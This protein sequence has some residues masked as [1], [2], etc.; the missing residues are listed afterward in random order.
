MTGG[1][2]GNKFGQAFDNAKDNSDEKRRMIQAVSGAAQMGPAIVAQPPLR[3]GGPH[4]LLDCYAG[5]QA[6]VQRVLSPFRIDEG[7]GRPEMGKAQ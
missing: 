5:D 3:P 7:F 4:E 1:R 6:L 2:N